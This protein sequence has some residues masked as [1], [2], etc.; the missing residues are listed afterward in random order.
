[1]GSNNKYGQ[2]GHGNINICLSPKMI[3]FFKNKKIKIIQISCGYSHTLALGD[4]GE[5]FSWGLGSEGQLGQNLDVEVNYN[6]EPIDF[7]IKNNILIYQVSAG[8][9]NSYFLTEDNEVYMCGSNG[10]N[11]IKEFVPKKIEVKNKYKDMENHPVW[12]CRILNC[13]NRS[14]SVF[15]TIF[16]DC[17][18]IDKDDERVHNVLDMISKRWLNQSYSADIMKGFDNIN[19]D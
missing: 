15:Y 13:W 18:F 7:F 10:I 16:L 9:H 1:M 2:L 5:V 17:N 8:Y 3:L 14:M 12:I 6:P 19:Y 11:Y 4:K